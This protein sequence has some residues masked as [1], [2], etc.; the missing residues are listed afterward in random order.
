MNGLLVSGKEGGG[1]SVDGRGV[2]GRVKAEQGG[3]KAVHGGSGLQQERREKEEEK[4]EDGRAYEG[5]K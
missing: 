1:V 5:K 4:G 2:E 3:E